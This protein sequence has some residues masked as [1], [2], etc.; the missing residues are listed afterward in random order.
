MEYYNPIHD[1]T[2]PLVKRALG[3]TPASIMCV[4]LIYQRRG[5]GESYELQ[6]VTPAE[7]KASVKFYLNRE[8][9]KKKTLARDNVYTVL[10]GRLGPLLY[11]LPEDHGLL[12]VLLPLR[13]ANFEPHAERV[14]RYEWFGEQLWRDGRVPDK[15]TFEGHY[16]PVVET[17][18]APQPVTEAA[19][20]EIPST[21]TI[22][23][24]GSNSAIETSAGGY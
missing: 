15:I 24:T 19:P 12:E 21:F 9:L 1:L 16:L 17:L 11:S 20:R 6:R 5:V 3:D 10:R 23:A 13:A 7:E 22:P 8:E 2:V 18:L 14:L 4:P